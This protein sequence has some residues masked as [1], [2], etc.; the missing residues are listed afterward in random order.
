MLLL[1]LVSLYSGFS[2]FANPLTR[3]GIK[4]RGSRARF[5]LACCAVFDGAS[6]VTLR[7]FP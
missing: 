1:L 4:Y 3:S 7:L 2:Y 6:E 5:L